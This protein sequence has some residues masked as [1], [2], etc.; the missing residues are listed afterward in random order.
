LNR[1]LRFLLAAAAS[2]AALP[3]LAGDSAT[4][5]A[6]DEAFGEH[7]KYEPVIVSL[8]KAVAA[9]DAAA[10]AKLVSY[11]IRVSVNGRK[12]TIRDAKAFVARYDA[13][14]TPDIA[15][16]VRGPEIR[17]PVRQLPG[18]HVRERTGVDQ[19]RLQ[20]PRMQGAGRESH[21]DPAHRPMSG[22]RPP[23]LRTRRAGKRRPRFTPPL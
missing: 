4:N 12:T 10:V 22:A 20:R 5:G 9:H 13:I 17:G 21:H 3:A 1:I 15:A 16:A 19:R 14:I 7:A 8:Q 11:P 2:A 23:P 18:R 6:I